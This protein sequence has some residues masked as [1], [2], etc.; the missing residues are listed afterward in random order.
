M[1]QPSQQ[2]THA[3][4]GFVNGTEAELEVVVEPYEDQVAVH[5]RDSAAD[6]STEPALSL[7]LDPVDAAVHAERVLS[8]ARVTREADA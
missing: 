5:F 4:E 7:Y 1:N 2:V 6:G 3:G 8:A